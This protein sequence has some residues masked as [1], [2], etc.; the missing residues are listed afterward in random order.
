MRGIDCAYENFLP[1][2]DSGNFRFNREYFSLI[3]CQ[4][5]YVEILFK[6][7]FPGVISYEKLIGHVFEA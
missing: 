4:V 5:R 1:D 6:N 2:P 3:Q 7:H